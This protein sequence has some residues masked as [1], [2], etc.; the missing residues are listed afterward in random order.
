MNTVG[1][2]LLWGG[3]AVVVVIMLSI[4]LLLQGRRGAHAM[5]MKQAAGWSILWV[6]LS[7]LFNAAFWWYLAETQGREVADP[8][9]LA[10]LTGYLIEKSL[11]VDNVFVWLMLFS[12]FSVPPA[13]QRRVLVYGVLGAIV[14][15]TIMIFAGTWLITQFEWLLYVFG[16]FLLFTGVKM[17]LA[18]EDESGIG[19]KP[20]VRWLRGHLRMTD[21]IENEHFFV[22]KNGLLYATPLLLVLIMVEFSDVIF[23]VDSIPAIFAVT[24]DPFIVLTSNL[25]AIL[26]LRAMY[27]LLSGVAERFSMLK[28]GL[29][30]ILVF[31]GIK[32][33]IVDFYHIPIAISLGVVFGI[34][35]ITLVIN[36]WVNHQRDKKL[37]A[38]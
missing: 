9:A 34:M 12:Y 25:F 35:T 3:F 28:Y 24:T 20:M 11:A 4:D 10:F 7:L 2:P 30:V 23:A 22:R 31:I 37:R 17:A 18:K 21:T 1:T 13:L 26:G 5:S 27:F 29:A 16:A 14:L 6:T 19:E 33:L 36:A 32:M 38:Q 8:Q 15:R